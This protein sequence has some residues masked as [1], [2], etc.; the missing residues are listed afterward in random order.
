MKIAR[1]TALTATQ[2]PRL[3]AWDT[4][5]WGIRIAQTDHP[6]VD[7]WALDN[8]VDLTCMLADPDRP[9]WIQQA[10]EQG[11]RY[12][13][14][15]VELAIT[16]PPY[17]AQTAIPIR[18]C[19]PEDVDQLAP[20][21]RR[22]HRITRFY[23]DPRLNT[24]LCDDLYEGW[25]RNSVAGWAQAVFVAGSRVPTGYVTVH[26][27]AASAS[28]GLIAVSESERGR[29]VGLALTRRAVTWAHNVKAKRITVVTQGRNTAALATF[30]KAGFRVVSTKIWLHRWSEGS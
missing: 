5:F 26:L 28:I 17:L 14:T 22:A 29:G 20:L 4:E 3:L 16:D 18:G 12:V 13:D 11:F 1:T 30:Q 27:D 7:Q 19:L 8:T 6:D 9:E 23:A 25:L 24:I 15:R 21:A 10:E 2:E